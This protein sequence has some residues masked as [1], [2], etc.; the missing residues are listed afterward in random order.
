[1]RLDIRK[2]GQIKDGDK[3]VGTRARVKVVKNK[4]APPFRETEFEVRF[5]EGINVIGELVDLGAAHGMIEKAGAWFAFDGERIG[6]GRERACEW[7]RQHPEGAD[8]LRQK[9]FAALKDQRELMPAGAPDAGTDEAAV[10]T[11]AAA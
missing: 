11:Q 7:L 9:L 5:G 2:T 1:M 10:A 6:Q 8:K 3:L 4:V